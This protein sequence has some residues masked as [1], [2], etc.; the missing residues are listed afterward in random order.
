MGYGDALRDEVRSD[1]VTPLIGIFDMCSSSLAAQHSNPLSM[2]FRDIEQSVY[3]W[4]SAIVMSSRRSIFV[5][6]AWISMCYKSFSTQS[7]PARAERHAGG[8]RG[9]GEH[10]R[11]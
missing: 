5:K 4:K 11:G 6:I 3:C 7:K 9:L 8:L 1:S 2:E 10:S